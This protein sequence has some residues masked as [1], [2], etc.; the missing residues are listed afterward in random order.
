MAGPARLGLNDLSGALAGANYWWLLPG[1]AVYFVGVWARAWRWHYLLRPLK[2]IPTGTMFPIVAIGYMGNNIYP[3]RAGELLR[4]YVL[5][6]KAGVPVSA[7][8]ATILIERIFDGVVMLMFV[9]FNLSALA[10]LS[11]D[12]G[13][14]AGRPAA[15]R[16]HPRKNDRHC[17]QLLDRAGGAALA[18]KHSD[19]VPDLG[20][21]LA[22]G[23]RQVLVCDARLRFQRLRRRLLRAD[24]DEWHCESGHHPALR[25]GLRGHV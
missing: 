20:G 3:A 19:G 12:S 21:D 8:L 7:S 2:R 1:V 22:V 18:A 17:G 25:A 6:R 4:A 24:V 14:P 16:P 13:S 10:T 23:D 9:F 11:H 15:A 5:R